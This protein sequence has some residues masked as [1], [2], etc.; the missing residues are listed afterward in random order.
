MA[1]GIIHHWHGGTQAEYD[2]VVKAVNAADGTLPD[3]QS[4]RIGGLTE[5]GFVVIGLHDTKQSWEQFRDDVLM[6][7]VIAGVVG[8]FTVQPVETVFEI[9]DHRTR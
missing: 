4:A 7:A 2:A 1:F 3:G 6:P 5:D 8:G 9:T